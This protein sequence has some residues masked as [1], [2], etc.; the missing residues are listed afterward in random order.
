MSWHIIHSAA[1]LLRC[2]LFSPIATHSSVNQ[3]C[4]HVSHH[5]ICSFH[6]S[7][8]SPVLRSWRQTTRGALARHIPPSCPTPTISLH[9]PTVLPIIHQVALI[10]RPL[11]PKPASS[12]HLIRIMLRTPSRRPRSTNDPTT[13]QNGRQKTVPT[14]GPRALPNSKRMVASPRRAAVSIARLHPRCVPTRFCK[15]RN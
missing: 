5:A 4:L 2:A 15:P 13:L 14:A 11:V 8:F 7:L 12:A 1:L 6:S 10:Q 9:A 3:L